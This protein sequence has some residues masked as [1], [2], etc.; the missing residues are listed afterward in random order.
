MEAGPQKYFSKTEM[1][2]EFLGK[3]YSTV[4]R[5]CSEALEDKLKSHPEFQAADQNR[6]F[7]LQVIK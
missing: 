2:E 1:Y 5:Q 6:F 4:I 7:L 3:L